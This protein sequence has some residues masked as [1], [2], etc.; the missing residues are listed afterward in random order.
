MKWISFKD[1]RPPMGLNIFVCNEKEIGIITWD[2]EY[3]NRDSSFL[4]VCQ[5]TWAGGREV[6]ELCYWAPISFFKEHLPSFIDGELILEK[7]H[8]WYSINSTHHA[9]DKM[10][11]ITRDLESKTK[12]ELKAFHKTDYGSIR[13]DSQQV[14]KWNELLES[15]DNPGN[16][17]DEL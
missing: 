3:T 10:K 9:I 4:R 8:D 13:Y 2:Q 12:Y 17:L 5:N 14:K 1:M 6:Y 16:E 15:I 11:E 7:K